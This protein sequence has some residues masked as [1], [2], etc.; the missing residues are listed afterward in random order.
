MIHLVVRVRTLDAGGELLPWGR[1]LEQIRAPVL[2]A[3]V[4]ICAGFG[5]FALSTFPPT[6]RF[7]MAV[8]LGTVT[9]ATM[10]LIVLPRISAT[11]GRSG[12]KA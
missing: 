9:A 11:A 7:G 5:I 12:A 4:I 8:I 1:A 3:S 10:T 6:R 2:R